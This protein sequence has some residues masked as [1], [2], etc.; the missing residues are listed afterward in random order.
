VHRKLLAV[1]LCAAFAVAACGDD[2]EATPTTAT[3]VADEAQQ[4]STDA[5]DAPERIVSMAPTATEILFAIGAG[6]QVVAVDDQSDFPEGVPVTDLSAY[7]PNIEAVIAYDPDLVV[8]AGTVPEDLTAGLEA[9]DIDVLALPAPSV[10]DEVYEQIAD[11]G[12][13][14]GHEDEA[15]DLV[16]GMRADIDDLVATVPER[17]AAPTYY[18]ELDNTLYSV[19]SSTFI[20]QLYALAG[21]ENVADAADPDGELGGYP[22]LSPEF[23]VDADPDFVFLADTECCQQDADTLAARP[24]FADLTA[25]QQGHV[26]ELSDDVASRWGPR[27]VDLLRTIIEATR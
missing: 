21:L 17:D 20:G 7:E 12:I 2:D 3:T 16:A 25:V 1:A 22:Q 19:T 24:G 8:T 13:A 6:D 5:G 15:A 4:P 9:A 10:L 23:L 26:V 27:I 14:S 18:H 11:V